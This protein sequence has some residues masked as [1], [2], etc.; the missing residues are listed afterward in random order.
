MWKARSAASC[1]ARREC[2]TGHAGEALP[3]PCGGP[4]YQHLLIPGQA[5]Y[6]DDPKVI[7][8]NS[9]AAVKDLQGLFVWTRAKWV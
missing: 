6:A 2:R 1:G 8:M 9:V 5:G 3:P 4:S 7:A